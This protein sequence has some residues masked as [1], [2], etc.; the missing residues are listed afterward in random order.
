MTASLCALA[1]L[2]TA[3]DAWIYVRDERNS[4]MSA[5]MADLKVA[6]KQLKRLGPGYLWFRRD[7]KQYVVRDGKAMEQIEESVR[8]QEELGQQQARLGKVQSDL[9]R[10][11]GAIGLRQAEASPDEQQELA[12]AQNALGREQNRIG[13]EQEKLGKKQEELGKQTERKV[14]ELIEASLKDGRATLVVD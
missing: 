4:S 12:R 8:P 11:Q 10:Q 2:A 9:G 3:P 13:R 6:L 1:L 7:G 5:S 14:H